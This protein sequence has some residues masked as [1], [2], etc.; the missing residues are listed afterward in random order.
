MGYYDETK[1]AY[2]EI[3]SII[4]NLTKGKVNEV[5]IN[6]MLINLTT[7]YGTSEKK[8]L[9]RL[10]LLC[11]TYPELYKIENDKF[12]VLTGDKE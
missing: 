3:E 9:K 1:R 6:K 7:K 12:F 5:S 4:K 8:I 2:E 10:N 11:K